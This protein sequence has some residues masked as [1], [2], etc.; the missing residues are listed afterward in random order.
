[1]GH[2]LTAKENQIL[3]LKT[4]LGDGDE[5]KFV[6]AIVTTDT[7]I[8]LAGSPFALPHQSGGKYVFQDPSLT[9][10]TGTVK[11]I[12]AQYVVYEDAGFTTLA[13]CYGV[14]L[15][16]W[17]KDE[18]ANVVVDDILDKVCQILNTISSINPG[19]E[20]VACIDVEEIY[21]FI[22]EEELCGVI[23]EEEL[24]GFI[25]EIEEL[26]SILDSPEDL[27]GIIVEED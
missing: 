27:V 9:F 14:D 23:I 19:A 24:I 16:V 15:D 18:S 3:V 4:Q 10:P 5:T 13:D 7:G 12:H 20:L 22:E 26:H 11:E 2:A 25:E 6:R 8:Q 17:Q 1:M 21:G